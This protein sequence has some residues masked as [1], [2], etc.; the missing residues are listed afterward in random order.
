MVI[1]NVTRR[2]YAAYALER[3][4]ELAQGGHVLYASRTVFVDTEDYGYAPQDVHQ[5]LAGLTPSD[6]SHSETYEAGS[7]WHD[8]FKLRGYSS[9][10]GYRDDLYI[11]LKLNAACIVIV[12]CSFHPDR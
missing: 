4:V 6:F 10:S 11:K 2:D 1:R 9:P 3:I 5:C 12:L 8:V 7:G